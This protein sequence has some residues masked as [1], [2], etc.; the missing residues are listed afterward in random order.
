MKD[1]IINGLKENCVFLVLT[2][3]IISPGIIISIIGCIIKGEDMVSYLQN[4][5][6]SFLIALFLVFSIIIFGKWLK[7]LLYVIS[8]SL[9]AID[10]FL[11]KVF[12]ISISSSVLTLIAETNP[13]ESQEFIQT[14]GFSKDAIMSYFVVVFIILIVIMC[15]KYHSLLVHKVSPLIKQRIVRYITLSFLAFIIIV[16][17][18]R[19][20]LL[21]SFLQSKTSEDLDQASYHNDFIRHAKDVYT[22]SIVAVHCLK[23]TENEIE[24]ALEKLDRVFEESISAN[25]D[26][27]IAIYVLGESYIKSHC[28][29]YGYTLNTTPSLDRELKSGNLFVFNDMI[30]QNNRT[31]NVMRNSFSCNSIA[32]GEYW[33]NQAFFPAVFKNAGYNVYMWDNQRWYK[34]HKLYTF[35]SNAF[36]FNQKTVD[37]V[38]TAVNSQA[39]KY[40]GD[41]I[42][43]F[44]NKHQTAEN[45][46][47][48]FHLMGQHFKTSKRYPHTKEFMHFTKDSIKRNESWMTD[49]NRNSIADYDNATRYND[50]VIRKI[51]DEYRNKCAFMVYFSD[52]G[53]EVYD[54]RDSQGRKGN[55]FLSRDF[56]KYQNEIPFMIW[57]SDS[58]MERYPNIISNLKQGLDRK[59]MTDNVCH[60]MFHLANIGSKNYIPE[61]DITSPEYIERKRII[62]DKYDYDEIMSSKTGATN[63]IHEN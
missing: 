45:A 52:H 60:I 55:N 1:R 7:Y 38:Y 15:E 35:T 59:G 11:L 18:G 34:T 58:Y 3:I 14:Y 43:D 27:I 2:T 13:R 21:I 44:I 40:D 31:S 4:L 23:A 50:Y 47:I 12:H 8:I 63:A 19:I 51:L 26:S 29:L 36:L 61:R 9:C 30:A 10:I 39:F 28:S 24:I 22:A 62:Y 37:M 48:F 42:D 5:A 6:L 25:D 56:L 33:Y 49:V 17:G 53:E 41:L 54:Y 57:C 46:L 16:G 20:S 32:D